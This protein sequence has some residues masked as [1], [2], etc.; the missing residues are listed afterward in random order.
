MFDGVEVVVG[1]GIGVVVDGF[2]VGGDVVIV[3]DVGLLMFFEGVG[4]LCYSQNS[5]VVIIFL[6]NVFSSRFLVLVVY[7]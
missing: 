6:F 1:V 4:D 3:G 5:V 7:C 2:V